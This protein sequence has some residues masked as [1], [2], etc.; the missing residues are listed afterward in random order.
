MASSPLLCSGSA[1]THCTLFILCSRSLKAEHFHSWF[2]RLVE[3][4]VSEASVW[5]SHYGKT[6][7]NN[8][9]RRKWDWM[10]LS[11]IPQ[12]LSH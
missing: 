9:I 5:K 4:V 11:T 7:P 10:L 6:I 12:A 2:V 8:I 3:K 1:V